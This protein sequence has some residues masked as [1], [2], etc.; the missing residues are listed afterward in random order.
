MKTDN[1]IYIGKIVATHGING[2]LLCTIDNPSFDDIDINYFIV[3]IDGTYIPFFIE[4]YRWKT[5]NSLLLK[6][7]HT[8]SQTEAQR[9]VHCRLLL[10]D[11]I[12]IEP[13]ADYSTLIGYRV[14]DQQQG[15][16]GT[17]I[18]IDFVTNQ[19]AILLID[20]DTILPLHEDLVSHI[21]NNNKIIYMN[22]PQGL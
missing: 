22:L 14:I 17:I 3:E 20:N 10:P 19:N 1:L 7:V 9:L 21:D 11:D 12:G 6:F 15:E 13:D 2:E 4:E 16:M 5:D 18:N 8:N